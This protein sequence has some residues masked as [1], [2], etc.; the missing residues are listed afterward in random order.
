MTWL[1]SR[2]EVEGP[3]RTTGHAPSTSSVMLA[4]GPSLRSGR[5]ASMPHLLLHLLVDPDAGI[6]RAGTDRAGAQL[7]LV[8]LHPRP[9]RR[10][11]I[12]CGQ[13]DVRRLLEDVR[14]HLAQ[15]LLAL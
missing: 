7:A 8:V 1:S 14:R 9:P 11:D 13:P 4:C 12:G 10:I 5:Q 6:D 3:H 2:G 15:H